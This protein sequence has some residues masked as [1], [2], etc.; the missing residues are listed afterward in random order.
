MVPSAVCAISVEWKMG[1]AGSLASPSWLL[2][3]IWSLD[4]FMLILTADEK[5]QNEKRT[6]T[7]TLPLNYLTRN[8]SQK[9]KERIKGEIQASLSPLQLL[10]ATQRRM[11]KEQAV[12]WERIAI[13]EMVFSTAITKSGLPPCTQRE[14]QALKMV[15][16]SFFLVANA[17]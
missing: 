1:T 12:C 13:L 14:L 3:R 11:K 4:V 5:A 8:S 17:C 2:T 16:V 7:L 10:L 6:S 15:V 9:V